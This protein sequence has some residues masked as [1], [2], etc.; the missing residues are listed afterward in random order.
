M[1]LLAFLGGRHDKKAWGRALFASGCRLP[2]KPDVKRY[3]KA[4]QQLISNDC[5][6]IKECAHVILTTR[7]EVVRSKNRMMMFSR[8]NHLAR[9]EPYADRQQ[10]EKPIEKNLKQK[11]RRHDLFK[12]IDA[13]ILLLPLRGWRSCCILSC[14]LLAARRELF[15]LSGKPCG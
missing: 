15:L 2:A 13:G 5:K 1:S 8:Y 11:M 10:R 3:E 12:Y 6:I 14:I 4:T 7:S 9:L